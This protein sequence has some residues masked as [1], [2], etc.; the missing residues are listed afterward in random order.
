M[1]IAHHSIKGSENIF[2]K[3]SQGIMLCGNFV[4]YQT[5]KWVNF[6]RSNKELFELAKNYVML[7]EEF[8][9]ELLEYELEEIKEELEKIRDVLFQKN[10]DVDKFVEYQQLYKRMNMTEY[11]EF[12]KTLE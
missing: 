5:F 4:S 10:Y 9:K 7:S 11:F 1:I 2:A 6:M 3:L 12:I 8:N